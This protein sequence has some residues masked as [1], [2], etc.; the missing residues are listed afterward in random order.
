MH[1]ATVESEF[2]KLAAWN[3]FFDGQ[4]ALA[5]KRAAALQASHEVVSE[6]LERTRK[7]SLLHHAA[8]TQQPI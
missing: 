2:G 7:V 8:T 1:R 3:P 5:A 4:A 6:L